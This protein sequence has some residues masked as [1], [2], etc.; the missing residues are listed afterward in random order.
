MIL[1][2]ETAVCLTRFQRWREVTQ[3]SGA[4]GHEGRVLS[5]EITGSGAAANEVIATGAQSQSEEAPIC[6]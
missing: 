1:A 4:T 3:G 5:Q 6:K 2:P